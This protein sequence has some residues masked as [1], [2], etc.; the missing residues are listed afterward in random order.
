[1]YEDRFKLKYLITY[2]YNVCLC[3][4]TMASTH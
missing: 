2:A 3:Q 1:M 4:L